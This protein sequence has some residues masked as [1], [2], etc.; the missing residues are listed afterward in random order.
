M[1]WF[2]RRNAFAENLYD[3]TFLMSCWFVIL[4]SHPRR[5]FLP[6]CSL[7][8]FHYFFHSVS[9]S[10]PL[11]VSIY[12]VFLY[13]S[14]SQ[15]LSLSLSL[16]RTI[17]ALVLLALTQKTHHIC[18]NIYEFCHE[19]AEKKLRIETTTHHCSVGCYVKSRFVKQ[20]KNDERW[21][22]R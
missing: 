11:S 10:L 9:F 12:I 2:L 14:I 3:R 4:P 17:R 13:I 21:K 6:Y 18:L 15:I 20:R 8:L 7:L 16:S 5:L 19:T 1:K 22:D